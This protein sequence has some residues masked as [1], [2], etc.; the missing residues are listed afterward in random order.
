[1]NNNAFYIENDTE[2]NTFVL[3]EDKDQFIKDGITKKSGAI[4][5]K[6]KRKDKTNNKKRTY[7]IKKNIHCKVKR[8]L[9][10]RISGK[11]RMN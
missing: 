10:K 3:K 7:K 2:N 8:T 6:L 1:M 5:S 11:F 4:E 9:R